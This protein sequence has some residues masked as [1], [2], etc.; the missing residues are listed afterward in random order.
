MCRRLLFQLT[1]IV[2]LPVWRGL[3]IDWKFR[4]ITREEID[5][6][7]NFSL[8]LFFGK[9]LAATDVT[10]NVLFACPLQRASSRFYLGDEFFTVFRVG[11][12]E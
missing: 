9:R 7:F 10:N 3:P 6:F 2:R 1:G 5:G 4:L 8:T 11:C 12:F